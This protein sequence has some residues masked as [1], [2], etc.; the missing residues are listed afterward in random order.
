MPDVE[1]TLENAPA[2]I[3]TIETS[4]AVEVTLENAPEVIVTLES[5]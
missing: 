3:V 2:V 4:L 1:V 5:A